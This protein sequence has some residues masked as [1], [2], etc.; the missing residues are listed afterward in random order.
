MIKRAFWG[1]KPPQIEYELLHDTPVGPKNI[2]PTKTVTLLLPGRYEQ[3]DKLLLK[4]GDSVETG[5]RLCPYEGNP[6]YVISSVTGTVTAVEPFSG[7]FGQSFTA[8]SLPGVKMIHFLNHDPSGTWE[9]ANVSS[10]KGK[11]YIYVIER[12]PRKS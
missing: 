5:Q 9:S 3:K 2:L 6:A 11:L 1:S 12:K 10:I 4:V 8:I 7:D